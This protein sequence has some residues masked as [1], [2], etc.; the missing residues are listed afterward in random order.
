MPTHKAFL[1]AAWRPIDPLTITPTLDIAGDRWSDVNTSPVPA[2]PYLRTGGSVLLDVSAQYAIQRDFDVVFG[3]KN[4]TD[5]NY[6]LS[7][8]FPQPGRTFYVKT[9]VGL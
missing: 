8:G 9:R 7:W 4:V 6:E 5:R 2:F 1:W 3:L